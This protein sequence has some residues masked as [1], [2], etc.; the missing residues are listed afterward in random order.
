MM[1]ISFD[2]EYYWIVDYFDNDKFSFYN[3]YSYDY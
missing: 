3:D 2:Y 1:I